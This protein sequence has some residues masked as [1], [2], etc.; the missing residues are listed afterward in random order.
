MRELSW[1]RGHHVLP[2][3]SGRRIR[4]S[5]HR[6]AIDFR[7]R[8]VPSML[9]ELHPQGGWVRGVPSRGSGLRDEC[10]SGYG[11]VQCSSTFEWLNTTF[12]N[13]VRPHAAAFPWA[14]I[15]TCS[16]SALAVRTRDVEGFRG[17]MLTHWAG[18]PHHARPSSSSPRVHQIRKSGSTC[19]NFLS[20]PV[21]ASTSGRPRGI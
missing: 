9:C 2:V 17:C 21:A 11:R 8:H 14:E 20:A 12:R 5:S 6:E 19:R 1:L 16:T 18:G 10:S 4:S 13:F 7:A 3:S 15:T